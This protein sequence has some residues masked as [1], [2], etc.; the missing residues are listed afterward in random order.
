MAQGVIEQTMSEWAAPIVVVRKKDGTIRL[1]VDYRRLNA[2]STVDAYPMP[3]V[4][5][6]IDM[7]GQAQYISTLDLTK[8]K[9]QW[10]MRTG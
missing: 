5:D 9:C 8:G 1:C 4:D 10:Q 6:L 3:R 7:I 2:V